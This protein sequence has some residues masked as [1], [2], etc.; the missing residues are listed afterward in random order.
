MS[1]VS[2]IHDI[3]HFLPCNQD[4]RVQFLWASQKSGYLHL[5]HVTSRLETSTTSGDSALDLIDRHLGNIRY[6]FTIWIFEMCISKFRNMCSVI[7][8]TY[9]FIWNEFS[10]VLFSINFIS[11]M[12]NLDSLKPNVI[13]EKQITIGEWEAE[14]KQVTR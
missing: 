8:F 5:Y 7:P 1:I 13:E 14:G 3:L 4:D 9:W 10:Y 2:Q 11:I 12:Y 6:S